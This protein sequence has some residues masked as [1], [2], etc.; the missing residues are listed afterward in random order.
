MKKYQLLYVCCI[1]MLALSFN[2]K[3]TAEVK[4]GTYGTDSSMNL[5][6]NSDFTFEYSNTGE[7]TK[8]NWERQNNKIVLK[9]YPSAN[10]LP[11]VWSMDKDSECLKSKKGL[12]FIRLC[13]QG[14]C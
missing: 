10:K 12:M 8:G 6:L 5:V 13:L 14:A 1:S 7:I 9:N 11:D 3:P 2:F 4:P